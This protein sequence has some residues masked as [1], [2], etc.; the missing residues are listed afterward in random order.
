MYMEGHFQVKKDAQYYLHYETPSGGG[1]LE[2]NTL[3]EG[4]ETK[5]QF[6]VRGGSTSSM[7]EWQDLGFH[8]RRRRSESKPWQRISTM[9]LS[10]GT[11]YARMT[12]AGWGC[13]D[14]KLRLEQLSSVYRSPLLLGAKQ[15]KTAAAMTR[16][17]NGGSKQKT[18]TWWNNWGA[19][20]VPGITVEAMP[21]R[22]R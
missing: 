19:I 13:P 2:F 3:G 16:S 4:S 15:N 18:T 10:R 8:H 7:W 20:P 21:K 9:T 22:T 14:Y 1:T 17:A 11:Y 5:P 6:Q 12:R